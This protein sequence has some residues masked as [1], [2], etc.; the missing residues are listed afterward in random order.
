MGGEDRSDTLDVRS[1]LHWASFGG[2]KKENASVIDIKEQ[3]PR[4]E[5]KYHMVIYTPSKVLS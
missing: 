4:T 2:T 5:S 3:G 1:L